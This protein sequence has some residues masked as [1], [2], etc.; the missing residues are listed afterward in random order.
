MKSI[1]KVMVALD[2]SPNSVETLDHAMLISG[3]FQAELLVINVIN[4]R[5]LNIIRKVASN[6]FDR[7]IEA[8]V[9]KAEQEYIERETQDRQEGLDLLFKDLKYKTEKLRFIFKVGV[10]FKEILTAIDEQQADLMVVGSK[11][12]TNITGVFR[13]STAEKLQRFCPIPLLSVRT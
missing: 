7:S 10:P 5:D 1:K 8:Y 2:L 11:G 9:E 12:N 13:G 4:S 3:Q 6:Q